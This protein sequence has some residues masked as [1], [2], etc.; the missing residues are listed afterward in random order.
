MT[1]TTSSAAADREPQPDP[2]RIEQFYRLLLVLER[3]PD[4]DRHIERALKLLCELCGAQLVYLELRARHGYWRG[5]MPAPGATSTAVRTRVS[6]G[7]V[8]RALREGTVVEAASG[9]GESG[10]AEI[11]SAR[12][13]ASGS[14]FCVPIA[15]HRPAGALYV[16][17]SQALAFADRSRVV[18]MAARL[19]SVAPK[20][21]RRSSSRLTLAEEIRELQERRILDALERCDGNIAR[22]SRELGVGRSFVYA[23]IRRTSGASPPDTPDT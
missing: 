19:V 2:K 11:A 12:Q 8:E 5:Y 14:V 7:I 3:A 18:L 22:V 21:L 15:R 1:S 20:L 4:T 6:H 17:S 13:D 9:R 10:L 16:Q 23:I